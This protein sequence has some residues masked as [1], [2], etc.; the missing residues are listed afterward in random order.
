MLIRC[1]EVLLR[2]LLGLL[3]CENRAESVRPWLLAL[4]L[5]LVSLTDDLILPFVKLC[6][7]N[8][9]GRG[10]INDVGKEAGYCLF[11]F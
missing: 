6:R 4:L 10:G 8:F 9:L 2:L 5:G 7:W 11:S 3:F 1:L